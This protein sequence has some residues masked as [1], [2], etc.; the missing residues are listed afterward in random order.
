MLMYKLSENSRILGLCDIYTQSTFLYVIFQGCAPHQISMYLLYRI[1]M[2]HKY[3]DFTRA[4]HTSVK[5]NSNNFLKKYVH[6]AT[7]VYYSTKVMFHLR[8]VCV[9]KCTGLFYYILCKRPRFER[10]KVRWLYKFV[11]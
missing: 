8:Y 6:N 11:K 10:K 1:Y 4:C 2:H 3:T 7:M 5:Y 9:K